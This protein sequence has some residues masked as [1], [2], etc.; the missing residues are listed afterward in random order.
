MVQNSYTNAMD[1]DYAF[2]NIVKLG[3][4]TSPFTAKQLAEF[5]SRL[6]EGIKNIEVGALKED[7]FDTIPKEHF[8]EIRRL[9]KLTNSSP[10]LHAPLLDPSGFGERGWSEQQRIANQEQLKS[11]IERAYQLD[12]QGN[13]PVDFHGAN[14][15]GMEWDATLGKKKI[16]VFD[17]K[18][19]E[20][21]EKEVDIPRTM[22]VVNQ[23]TGEMAPLQYE[24]RIGFEGKEDIWDPYKR[25][26]SLNKTTWDEEKLK[27]LSQEK[28]MREL[29]SE[30]DYLQKQ[31]EPYNY[32]AERNIPLTPEEKANA[33]SII[34]NLN[35]IQGHMSEIN[36]HTRSAFIELLNKFNRFSDKNDKE[37]NEFINSKEGEQF[38]Y[39]GKQI[40]EID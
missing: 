16:N 24:K 40:N 12:P 29:K 18:K 27:I 36:S 3:A 5:G 33:S 31:L 32:A 10:S 17:E 39:I 11:V 15:F 21:V 37:Y 9:A 2:H 14:V 35:S 7:L 22:V 1:S 8:D 20:Y 25:L 28:I 13:I 30:G 23:S 4:P 38:N 26:D 19:K 34:R 6:N